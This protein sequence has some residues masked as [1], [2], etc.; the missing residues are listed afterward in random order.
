MTMWTSAKEA[1]FRVPLLVHL[2]HSPSRSIVL[3]HLVH[4]LKRTCIEPVQVDFLPL[5]AVI[6]RFP[7]YLVLGEVLSFGRGSIRGPNPNLRYDHLGARGPV[8]PNSAN[9]LFFNCRSNQ[10]RRRHP[11]ASRMRYRHQVIIA[12]LHQKFPKAWESSCMSRLTSSRRAT[13]P[14]T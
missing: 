8:S 10:C 11:R 4:S 1:R 2:Y 14:F 6:N 5:T 13:R 12:I 3:R 9:S 7:Q